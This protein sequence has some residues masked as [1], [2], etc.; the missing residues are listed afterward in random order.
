MRTAQFGIGLGEY[1]SRLI[2]KDT[3]H[4]TEIIDADAESETADTG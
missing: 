3:E 4:L 1:L 2:L